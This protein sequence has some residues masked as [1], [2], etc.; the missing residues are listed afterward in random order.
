MDILIKYNKRQD[1]ISMGAAIL[2]LIH[3]IALPLFFSTLPLFGFEILE[4]IWLETV[5]ILISLF[6][7]GTAIWKGFKNYHHR[8]MVPLLF[9]L[10]MLL[11]I[12]G[13]LL[14]SELIEMLTKLVGA[15]FMIAAHSMN[16]YSIHHAAS[17]TCQKK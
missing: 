17:H 11:M 6:I 12:I 8:L 14:G 15:G 10:G 4:N 7:G 16:W 3:C 2:C 5:T 13:N 1:I 9:L